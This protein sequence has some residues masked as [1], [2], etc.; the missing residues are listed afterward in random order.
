MVRMRLGTLYVIW[1]KVIGGIVVLA[2]M[3]G[4]REVD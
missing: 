3:F 2:V 4:V 1:G